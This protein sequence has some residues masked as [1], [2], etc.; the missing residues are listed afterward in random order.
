MR[1]QTYEI[2]VILKGLNELPTPYYMLDC[3]KWCREHLT[4]EIANW[5]RIEVLVREHLDC[6]PIQNM[7][8]INTN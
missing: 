7:G 1:G 4:G 8:T 5:W 3:S 6:S 2:E